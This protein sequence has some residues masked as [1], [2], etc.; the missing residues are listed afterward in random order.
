LG[1][2]DGVVLID[3]SGVVKQGDDS[4]GVAAQH[5]GLVGKVANSQVRVYLGYASRQGYSWVAG[6]LFMPEAW[7]DDEHAVKRIACGV[8]EELEFQTMPEIGLELLRR[9]IQRGD[10]P[11]R[12][13]AAD[14]LYGDSPAFRDGVAE[15][16]RL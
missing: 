15:L 8:P 1:E 12:W 4:V 9:A 16:N 10:L 7:F 2:V 5:R 14:A 3:E 13:V 11:F 6:Q